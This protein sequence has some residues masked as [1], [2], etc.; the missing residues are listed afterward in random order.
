[1]RSLSLNDQRL[2]W[3]SK[4]ALYCFL[5]SLLCC[6]EDRQ[7]SSSDSKVSRRCSIGA[8]S[9]NSLMAVHN[10]GI[11]HLIGRVELIPWMRWNGVKLMAV[12]IAVR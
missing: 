2:T 6:N 1:M 9:G 8:V 10:V 11:F 12:L 4:V 5:A 3:R 7:S